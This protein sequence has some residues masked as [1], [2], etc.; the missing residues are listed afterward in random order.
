MPSRR[1]FLRHASAASAVSGVPLLLS[2]RAIA[3]DAQRVF[4]PGSR[5]WRTFE[6]TTRVE[7]D[8]G[9]GATQVWVPVPS[10]NTNWQRSLSD[11]FT[12]NGQA[13]VA[14]DGKHGVKMVHARFDAGTRKAIVEV[15]NRVQTRDRAID[16]N[17]L[18][19]AGEDPSTLA[20]WKQSTALIPT[21]GIVRETALRATRGAATDREKVVAIYD[22][23]A[24]NT[25]RE[26]SVRG[27]GEGDVVAMLKSGDPAGKCADINALFVGMC[28][29]VGIPARDLYGIRV[30][31]SAF[32]YRE[33]GGNPD[34]LAAAQH[35]RAEAYL[36][37]YG[38][39]AMDPADVTKVMR[40]ESAQWIKSVDHPLVAPVHEKLKGCCEGNWMAY[41]PA[42][43]VTLPGSRGKPLAFFMY[44]IAE[45]AGGRLDSYA[46]DDLRYR[47]FSREIT[48]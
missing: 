35:C 40:Q 11:S 39:V 2:G 28:R 36:K 41:N 38:W 17:V 20:V 9:A 31:A 3:A 5:T 19:E 32:G 12:S 47:I 26:P 42:H 46:P 25:H 21:D 16:W 44:P 30:A 24:R 34:K 13:R 4:E 22:W 18:P 45:T 37:G 33:L 48:A 27:C 7:I 1:D 8:A 6:V 43:D 15:T 23:V 29:A 14:Q 10:V